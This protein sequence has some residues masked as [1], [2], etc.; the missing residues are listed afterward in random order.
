M[1][2]NGEESSLFSVEQGVVVAYPLLKEVEE[3]GLGVQL[4]E[5]AV[6]VF[7]RNKVKRKWM[8]ESINFLRC[9]AVCS[10]IYTYK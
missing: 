3:A 5:S 8:W 9:V 4:D 6:M 7:A 10:Y 2:F 1:L